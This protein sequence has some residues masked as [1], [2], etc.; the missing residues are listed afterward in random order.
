MKG[1]KFQPLVP[2]YLS[3][4]KG[5]HR[6]FKVG[7]RSVSTGTLRGSELKIFFTQTTGCQLCFNPCRTVEDYHGG[8]GGQSGRVPCKSGNQEQLNPDGCQGYYS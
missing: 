5:G 8:S 2:N 7:V 6:A 3:G 1:Y 4:E